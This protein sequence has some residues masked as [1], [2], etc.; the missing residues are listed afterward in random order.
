MIITDPKERAARKLSA[1]IKKKYKKES[2][3]FLTVKE[4]CDFTG[5]DEE[6]LNGFFTS[7]VS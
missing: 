6:S 2:G 7:K 4:F 3:S 5:F 1:K